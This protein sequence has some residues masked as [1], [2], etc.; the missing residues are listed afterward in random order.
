VRRRAAAAAAPESDDD[1]AGDM[2]DVYRAPKI[3]A[4][5]YEEDDKES[6]KRQKEKEKLRDRLKKS[7]TVQELRAE[8]GDAPEE[9]RPFKVDEVDDSVQEKRDE[10]QQFEEDN[11]LRLSLSKREQKKMARPSAKKR[12]IDMFA[13][14]DDFADLADPADRRPD[15]DDPTVVIA[16]ARQKYE[17]EQ[18]AKRK[19]R[20]GDEDLPY[21][22][23]RRTLSVRDDGRAMADDDHFGGHDTGAAERVRGEEDPMYREAAE[24]SARRRADKKELARAA[25][26]VFMGDD[27]DVN[28]GDG[29]RAASRQML[30]N[31]G[32][33]SD[34][35]KI[36]RNPRAKKRM[37]F[38]KAV[39]KRKSQGAQF[40]PAAR[41]KP[42]SGEATGIRSHVTKSV[43]YR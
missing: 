2:D 25:S 26:Q 22:G 6:R 39:I 8:Y 21:K 9:V 35:K 31:R 16:K 23:D 33:T 13:D 38:D 32:L 30:K 18:R 3:N 36:N 20:G 41:M 29:K 42:Y 27:D 5:R 17:D 40:D 37:Q 24:R 28:E 4:V 34:R 1:D 7:R 19:R 12:R 43:K 11:F 14:F 10:V 15:A